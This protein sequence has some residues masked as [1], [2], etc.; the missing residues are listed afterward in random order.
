MMLLGK[1]VHQNFVSLECVSSLCVQRKSYC[2]LINIWHNSVSSIASLWHGLLII[3]NWNSTK[4]KIYVN[5]CFLSDVSELNKIVGMLIKHIIWIKHYPTKT[6]LLPYFKSNA[7]KT[8]LD[9]HSEWIYIRLDTF[10]N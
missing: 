8:L 1:N 3:P 10:E 5:A 9:P 4:C 2:I 7:T 6:S